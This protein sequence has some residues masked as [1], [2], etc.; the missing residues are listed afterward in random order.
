MNGTSYLCVGLGAWREG[1]YNG[2]HYRNMRV[3]YTVANTKVDGVEA[4][5]FS[6]KELPAALRVGC[7]FVPVFNRYG[8]ID[9]LDVLP[10][11]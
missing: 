11:K 4:G 10:E 6:I 5:F 7:Q 9:R 2:N 8:K 1:D 3:Y